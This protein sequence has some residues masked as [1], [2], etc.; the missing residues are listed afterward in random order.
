MGIYI[1]NALS[2]TVTVIVECSGDII[3][4]QGI[5]KNIYDNA[6]AVERPISCN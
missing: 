4:W 6:F 3:A 5:G 2:K 1:Q